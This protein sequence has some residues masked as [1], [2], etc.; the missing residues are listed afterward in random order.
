[1]W[2]VS[3]NTGAAVGDAMKVIK[4]QKLGV[5]TRTFEHERQA[6]L[7]VGIAA[8]VPMR[9]TR[10]LLSEVSMW[11]FLPEELG[12]DLVI[13]AGMPKSRGEYLVTGR[14]YPP[15]GHA[16]ST[17]PVRA[18]V[19]PLDKA[20]SV[21]GDRVWDRGVPTEP[22]LFEELR[23]GWAA[24]FGGEGCAENPR[25][26]GMPPEE[27]SDAPHR[28]PN[29]EW[30]GQLVRSPQERPAPA[31]FGPL[32]FSWPQ[33]FSRA[34]TYDGAWLKERFPGYA[35]DI[36]WRIFNVASDD[37]HLDGFFRGD[38]S[39]RFEGLHPEGVIEGQLPLLQTRCFI[40]QA[41]GEGS[42]FREVAMRLSTAWFF[43]HAER[44]VLVF[45]GSI[46]VGEDDA[47]DV[48]RLMIAGEELGQARE[49]SHYEA[50]L[51]KRLD[52]EDGYLEA[53]NDGDLTP[54]GWVD[55]PDPT[56]AEMEGLLASE[57]LM[58]RNMKARRERDHEAARRRVAAM[59]LD[60]DEYVPAMEDPEVEKPPADMSQLGAYM[61]RMDAMA[62]ELKVKAEKERAKAEARAR[63]V[64]AEA[65]V[66]VE[67]YYSGELPAGPPQ[68]SAAAQLANL[69][70]QLRSAREAG[71]P[72]ESLEEQFLSEEFRERL[73]DSE[74]KSRDAYRQMAHHQGV[75]PRLE[76]EAAEKV[77]RAVQQALG[78]GRSLVGWDL[79]GADLR[80]IDL[81][82]ECLDHCFLES[83]NLAGMNLAG[84]SLANAVLARADLSGAVLTGANLSGANLGE[85]DLTE[86]K[87]DGGANL[88]GAIFGKA[89]VCRTDLRQAKMLGADVMG[90]RFEEA[91]LSGADLR[92]VLFLECELGRSRMVGAQLGQATFLKVD[93]SGVDFTEA[94]LEKVVFVESI[95]RGAVFRNAGAENLRVVKDSDFAGADFVGAMLRDANLR[96]TKLTD[97]DFSGA[98]L[99]D[100][101]LSECELDR[102]KFYRATAKG[103]RL[104]KA[105]LK[106]AQLVS[107][108]L[109]GG[110]VQKADLCGA[111]LRGAN[112]FE[113]DFSRVAIDDRTNFTDAHQTRARYLPLRQP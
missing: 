15:G 49:V 67:D 1:M 35:A 65:G 95:G 97:A 29:V 45:H 7:G 85:A 48:L 6:Y 16:A 58:A 33:R 5:L 2:G 76:G 39:Y 17:C 14:A 89:K 103:A 107:V 22:A 20:L 101:D 36:D 57:G 104:E 113:A 44:A 40:D 62:E 30:P 19:G 106:D 56:Q 83:A 4:P 93:A 53:L 87:L 47:A 34:G 9:Q 98:E 96:G 13:D 66:R 37:Q 25:G 52:P 41:K 64:C 102:A 100:A 18:Q 88:E 12:E 111:D 108:N 63:Q 46:E 27:G 109:M 84:V 60:P 99:G 31:G 21:I 74:R 112:L 51:A 23:L 61:K 70:E 90:A 75:A 68:F 26:K 55:I 3:E 54:P 72:M 81:V 86:T 92:E 69:E 91:D 79:T 94:R 110:S 59:G 8:F 42:E 78:A 73:I 50:V 105:S 77:R 82:G 43:P 80:G 24:S 10:Q 11:K 71:Q 38:E 28:L 32:D